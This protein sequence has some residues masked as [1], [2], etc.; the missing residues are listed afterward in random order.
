MATDPKSSLSPVSEIVEKEVAEALAGLTP[1]SIRELLGTML[2][3]LGH[4]E[5]R[6]YLDRV[7]EDKGNGSYGRSLM[8]GSLPVEIE[9]PRTRSGAFRPQHLPAPYAR[10]YPEETQ[11]LLLGLLAASR[12]LNAAKGALRQL[13]LSGS[14][15]DIE[16]VASNFVEELNLRN[17][18]PVD[19]DLLA[20]FFDGKYVEVREGDRLRPSTIYLVI[21]LGRDGKKRVLS[22]VCKV[23]RENLEDWKAVLRNIIERGL[24]RVLLVVQDDFSGLLPV[25]KGLF[26]K[27]DVQLCIVHMQRNAKTHLS[28]PD[29]VEFSKRIRAVKA[30]WSEEV[31]GAQF[32]DLCDRFQASYPTFIAE[33]RKKREHYLAFIKY[34]DPIRRSFSTTNVVEA[35]NGQLEIMRRNSGGYFHSQDTLSLKLGIAIGNLENGR[36]RRLAASVTNALDQLNAIFEARFESES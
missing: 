17:T 24:R 13:G 1:F 3:E 12:S 2:T 31:A 15:Q 26:P 32:E 6:A 16:V 29:A 23:G 18:R 19:P 35:V 14:E 34:P 7:R 36:W 33:L 21:G 20:L 5:R 30:A 22:C 9:V 28:K 8:V 25:T 4:T 10:G 27:A 11:S